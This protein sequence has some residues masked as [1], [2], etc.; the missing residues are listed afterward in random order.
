MADQMKKQKPV[1]WFGLQAASLFTGTVN[2]MHNILPIIFALLCVS[3]GGIV[4]GSFLGWGQIGFD[5]HDWAQEGPRY[6]FIRQ[7]LLEGKLPLFIQSEMM[8]TQRFLSIPDVVFSPQMVLLRWLMPGE[9]VLVNALMLYLA[10]ALGVWQI[11]KKLNWSVFSFAITLGLMLLNGFIWSHLGVGHSM[12]VSAFLL[13]FFILLVL[14][15][16][17]GRPNWRWVFKMALL[18]LIVFAQGGFHFVL[19]CLAFLFLVGLANIKSIWWVVKGVGFSILFCLPRI[20][21]AAIQ[22]GGQERRFISGF[23]SL[24]DLF[25]SMIEIQLPYEATQTINSGLATWETN[26]YI[27]FIGF[28]L[29][30]VFGLFLGIKN[31][32]S[33]QVS[34]RRLGIPVSI[35]TLFSIG[36]FFLPINRLPLPLMDAERVSS[37]WFILPLLILAVVAIEQF[38]LWIKHKRM[39]G[40]VFGLLGLAGLVLYHDLI[41][42]A[43]L[44]RLEMLKTI[45]PATP[46]NLNVQVLALDDPLYLTMLIVGC[47]V[48][49]VAAIALCVLIR[50]ELKQESVQR[51]TG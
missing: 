31:H 2:H 15:L 27:G 40:F 43:R 37:R 32:A 44:W 14:A 49:S 29:I 30:V 13:P 35:F 3:L 21:P 51:I 42:N 8:D 9:F 34:I 36:K 16:L 11:S 46:V 19:W 33:A 38:D 22:F 12:W 50:K 28:A 47:F 48:M 26:F 25:K 39:N 10:G 45:F 4:L 5:F 1:G 24:T 23:L 18:M 6:M 17:G 7:A 20:L 41:Q